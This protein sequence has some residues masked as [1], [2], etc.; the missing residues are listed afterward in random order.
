MPYLAGTG[1]R[2]GEAAK[3]AQAQ[4]ARDTN[5]SITKETARLQM[6]AEDYV[7]AQVPSCVV[8]FQ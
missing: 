3:Q 5:N 6:E 2:L 1:L 4:H 8:V 7:P